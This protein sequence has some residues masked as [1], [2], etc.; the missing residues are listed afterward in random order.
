MK[1]QQKELSSIA[2]VSGL[3]KLLFCLVVSILVF[4]FLS[5]FKIEI[6]SRIIIGW[7]TFSFSMI[8]LSWLFFFS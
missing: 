2:K 7:D 5:F 1:K 8:I 6:F 3:K 4:V